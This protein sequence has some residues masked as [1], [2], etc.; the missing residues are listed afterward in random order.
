[1]H[2]GLEILGGVVLIPKGLLTFFVETVARFLLLSSPNIHGNY[3]IGLQRITRLSF[4]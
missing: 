3:L 2:W 1:M 4:L